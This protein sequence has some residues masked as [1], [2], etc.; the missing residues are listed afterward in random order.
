MTNF[1]DNWLG[2]WDQAESE[3]KASR[4]NIHEEE[5]EWVETAQDHQAA[6]M[7]SPETGFRT[8]GTTTMTAEIPVGGH[9]GAHKHGEEAIFIVDG[10]G[11]SIVDGLKYEWRRHSCVAIPFGAVHQ[12]FN[13]GDVPVRYLSILSVHLEHLCGLHRTIQ[14]ERFGMTVKELE[15]ETSPNGLAP[16]GSRMVLHREDAPREAGEGDGVPVPNMADLPEF[17]P[18]HPLILGDVDG[19]GALPPGLHQG[20]SKTVGF[21]SARTSRDGMNDF[22]VYENEISGVLSA[23]AHSYNGMHAHMEAHLYCISGHG[24]TLVDGEKVTW[25]KGTAWWVPGPQTPHR[26]FNEADEDNEMLRI[27]FGIRYFF[28][29]VAKREFPYL[30]LSPRQGVLESS[31]RS[32][33]SRR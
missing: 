17:D 3:R 31:G 20:G 30:F 19:M 11:Y 25:K 23:A 21:M 22:H 4:K 9:S 33:S 10:T 2:M 7:I 29:K 6:L 14:I 15:V 8:W 18:E 16:N 1:Y 26:H 32:G 28:E 12:H 24:Y 13:T 27:A 5:L